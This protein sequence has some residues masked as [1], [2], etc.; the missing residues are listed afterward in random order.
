MGV[1]QRIVDNRVFLLGLD[2]LYREAMK[3]HERGE[4]LACAR[5]VAATLAVK[6]ADV[7]VEGYYAEEEDLTTYFRLMRALQNV[8][9]ERRSE[10]GSLAAFQRL[11]DVASAPLY[12]RA[13]DVDKLLPTGRDPLSQ[14][15]ADTQPDWS[16]ASLV[17][18]A[19]TCACD[20]D[21]FSLVGLAARWGD[22]VVLTALRESVVLCAR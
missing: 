4:L 9:A 20:W 8:Y 12:G 16:M 18:T 19:S 3:R 13:R 7:P 5:S 14:A 22:A 10:V 15:L 11:Y 21:D 6:A 2:R 17:S 1:V